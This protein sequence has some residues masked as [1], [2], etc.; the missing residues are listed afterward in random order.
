MKLQMISKLL[1]VGALA[2]LCVTGT[3]RVTAADTPHR[4]EIVAKRFSFCLAMA[5]R[6]TSSIRGSSGVFCD[7]RAKRPTGRGGPAPQLAQKRIIDAK[8]RPH[9]GI[10]MLLRIRKARMC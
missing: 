5:R 10:M 8:R 3:R 1:I 6:T 4:I 7:G 2:I 9:N